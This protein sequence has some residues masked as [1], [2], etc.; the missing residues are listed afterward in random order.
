MPRCVL[1]VTFLGVHVMVS[2]IDT[3][4]LLETLNSIIANLMYAGYDRKMS[5]LVTSS[6]MKI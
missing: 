1:K 4:V 5:G 2:R 3:G 6:E